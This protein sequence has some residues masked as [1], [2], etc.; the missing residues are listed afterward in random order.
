MDL[1]PC[2]ML[3]LPEVKHPATTL[4]DVVGPLLVAPHLQDAIPLWDMGRRGEVM[5]G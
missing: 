5:I 4:T 3:L 2:V 1:V